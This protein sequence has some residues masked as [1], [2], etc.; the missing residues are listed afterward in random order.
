MGTITQR[1][2]KKGI[3]SWQVTVR[4]AGQPTITA[5]FTSKKDAEIF[6]REATLRIATTH[7]TKRHNTDLPPSGDL[8]DEKLV[9]TF[10]KFAE[11][12]ACIPRHRKVMPAIVRNLSLTTTIRDLKTSW[13]TEY[14]ARMRKQETR[15]KT[16]YG[17]ESIV[18]QLNMINVVLKWR[19]DQLDIEVPRLRF[20]TKKFPKDWAVKRTRRLEAGEEEALMKRLESISSAARIHWPLL[21]KLAIE[22]GARLQELILA[23]WR[24]ISSNTDFWTIPKMHTK[25]KKER[26]MPL[27]SGAIEALVA[28]KAAADPT[29]PRIFHCLGQ[30]RSVS[31]FFHR[32]SKEAG[33]IDLRFHDLRHDA[34]SRFVL[35]Q[36]NF[37]VHEIMQ[38]VGH[39]N[40]AMLQRY[41]NLR[42]EEL[43]KK[44]VKTCA[45]TQAGEPP[46][47]SSSPNMSSW[48][49]NPFGHDFATLRS[50]APP[51]KLTAPIYGARTPISFKPS[52]SR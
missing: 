16:F 47:L 29:D 44:I 42:G 17:Y 38:M 24:E 4:K 7:I 35:T 36:R 9:E 30:P 48:G 34:I 33:L 3:V 19:A 46:E 6:D 22:T 12:D 2:S 1:S 15:R 10:A 13:G 26:V 28:L 25:S 51:P 40:P 41:S 45:P 37:S 31:A 20:D 5:T 50:Q 52:P 39:S 49:I 23:E 14:I 8:R 32:M 43:A 11:S 21:A 27:T 18:D